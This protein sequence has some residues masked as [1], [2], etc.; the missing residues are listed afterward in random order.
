MRPRER[1]VTQAKLDEAAG[2]MPASVQPDDQP[3]L[4]PVGEGDLVTLVEWHDEVAIEF[5]GRL[6]GGCG[7]R[8]REL[9]VRGQHDRA[10][11]AGHRS[12][13][14]DDDGVNAG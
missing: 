2:D 1:D 10:A 9:I 5:K 11:D 13:R 3:G 12:H 14:R 4:G 7:Q 8:Q 6:P